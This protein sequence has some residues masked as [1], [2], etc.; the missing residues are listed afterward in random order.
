MIPFVALII[1]SLSFGLSHGAEARGKKPPADPR[2]E[3][4]QKTIRAKEQCSS[5][6]LRSKFG[7]VRDQQNV[8]WCYAF[9]Y[10]DLLG[11]K[12]KIKPPDMVSAFDVAV[13]Y[14]VRNGKEVGSLVKDGLYSKEDAS[15][16]KGK[17]LLD[18]DGGLFEGAH[19]AY[20]R[21]AKIC[22]ES[23]AP[24]Q[25]LF[26]KASGPLAD[27]KN[28]PP[29]QLRWL[30]AHMKRTYDRYRLTFRREKEPNRD[31]LFTKAFLKTPLC[32]T[33]DDSAVDQEA[34]R[35]AKITNDWAAAAIRR[36]LDKKC[37]PDRRAWDAGQLRGAWL[38]VPTERSRKPQ[39]KADLLKA[40]NREL[41]KENPV[42]IGYR[43]C[44][45]VSAVAYYPGGCGHES[46]LV[47]RNWNDSTSTCEY[48]VRN[49]WGTDCS[50][51]KPGIRCED[52]NFTVGAEELFGT[53]EDIQHF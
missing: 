35:I 30:D 40:A 25:G 22:L 4:L 47:G 5:V 50:R 3:V 10:A 39:R 37:A 16:L 6:D 29:E 49:S 33:E 46:L 28:I 17:N 1:V 2:K 26:E 51:Y 52:G 9:A 36:E 42:A 31:P 41:S 20:A 43:V 18:R 13:T 7:R 14:A 11:Y 23:Q 32:P 48:I 15:F 45:L 38:G 53:V 12:L 21:R 24:S 27:R 44:E 19:E 34:E 8:G